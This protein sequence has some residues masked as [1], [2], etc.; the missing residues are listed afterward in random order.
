LILRFILIV[1]EIAL[2]IVTVIDLTDVSFKMETEPAQNGHIEHPTANGNHT[3]TTKT[4]DQLLE[5]VD[6]KILKEAVLTYFQ[7]E[8]THESKFKSVIVTV[9]AKKVPAQK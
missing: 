2:E 4:L 7:T 5:K 6:I 9:T 8:P 3:E 1:I